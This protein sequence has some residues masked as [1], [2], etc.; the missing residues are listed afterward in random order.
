MLE[1]VVSRS[2]GQPLEIEVDLTPG[3]SKRYTKEIVNILVSEVHRWRK[4]SWLSC[5]DRGLEIPLTRMEGKT[6][7]LLE[8]LY[9][10]DEGCPN[11]DYE[12]VYSGRISTIFDGPES[13]PR[14]QTL[15]LGGTALSWRRHPFHDLVKLE[16]CYIPDG[17]V[18]I[19]CVSNI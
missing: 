4:L 10:D 15:E 12:E 13:L 2:K 16:I 11:Q 5:Q 3:S 1:M 8:F 14:L 9:L 17:S 6:A 18:L 19:P 7:P